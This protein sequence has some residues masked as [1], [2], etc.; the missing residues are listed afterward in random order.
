MPEATEQKIP[1]SYET[2]ILLNVTPSEET[3]SYKRVG[4]GIESF[5][6]TQNPQVSTKQYI[7]EINASSAITSLQKQF[8]Y[9]GERV[10]GDDVNDFLASL[11]DKVGNN[12]KTTLIKYNTWEET[13][14]TGTYNAKQ[15]EVVI[16]PNNDGDLSGGATQA[17][18]GT[19]YVNGD[20][21]EGTFAAST[22]TFTPAGAA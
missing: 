1:L 6:G 9:S 21:I 12:L 16:A 13:E 3:A 17:I 11:V 5:V 20:P 4:E 14:T 2:V 22:G 18:S 8:A 10:I 19:I 7:H 15:Y